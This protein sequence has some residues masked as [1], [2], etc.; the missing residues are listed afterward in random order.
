MVLV[1]FGNGINQINAR[2]A[3]G[4]YRRFFAAQRQKGNFSKKK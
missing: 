4:L 1:I 2:E 3:M